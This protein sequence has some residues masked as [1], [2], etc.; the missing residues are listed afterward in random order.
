MKSLLFGKVSGVFFSYFRRFL[1]AQSPPGHF[2]NSLSCSAGC[3]HCQQA[4]MVLSTRGFWRRS[5]P[6]PLRCPLPVVT[7]GNATTLLVM[8][9]TRSR[10]VGGLV[11]VMKPRS[12]F[13]VF[14]SCIKTAYQ[15]SSK[16][17]W[18]LGQTLT[19]P[20]QQVLEQFLWQYQGTKRPCPCRSV[21]PQTA[22]SWQLP[23]VH[24]GRF[25]GVLYEK[26]LSPSSELLLCTA[27]RS[28]VSLKKIALS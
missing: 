8:A 25:L 13:Q 18:L 1:C 12:Y 22:V 2:E 3:S 11:L 24:L 23:E 14:K 16:C 21:H 17:G 19:W 15:W 26:P 6:Q 10:V 4:H 9:S 20:C 5:G 28:V 27:W 7:A